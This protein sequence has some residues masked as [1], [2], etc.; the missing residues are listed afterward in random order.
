MKYSLL[1]NNPEVVRTLATWIYNEWLTSNPDSSVDKVINLISP[2]IN[3]T[4]VP[5]SIVAFTDDGKPVG[6]ASLTEL[7]MKSH[8]ELTPWLGSVYVSSEARG[9][10]VASE[11]CKRIENETKRLGHSKL[12]LFTEDQMALYGRMGWTVKA[13]EEYRGLNVTIMEKDL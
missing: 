6:T 1:P 8:P 12:Y 4:Q 10:G 9:H 7:D 5:L 2:R 13:K 3:S 11:L